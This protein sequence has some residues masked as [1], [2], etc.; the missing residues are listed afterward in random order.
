MKTKVYLIEFVK[1]NDS[2]LYIVRN[3]QNPTEVNVFNTPLELAQFLREDV[4]KPSHQIAIE[5]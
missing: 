4:V 3:P 1:G 2:E 5:K